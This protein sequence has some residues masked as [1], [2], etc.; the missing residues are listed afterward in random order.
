MRVRLL[1]C[2]LGALAV[3]FSV[4][5]I[6]RGCSCA[7]GGDPR[8]RLEH[9]AAA[10]IG[11]AL[12]QPSPSP[13]P[14]H[15][16]SAVR[17]GGGRNDIRYAVDEDFKSNLEDEI[18]VFGAASPC[19]FGAPVGETVAMYL[20]RHKG[21]WMSSSCDQT[22][23]DV[24]RRSAAPLP[25]PDGQGPPR[26]VLGGSMGAVRTFTLDA[27]GRT[28]R[29]AEGPGITSSLDLCPG[30]NVVAELAQGVVDDRFWKVNV[31]TRD[32]RTLALRS[33]YGFTSLET[34]NGVDS[35]G[36]GPVA[37]LDEEGRMLAVFGVHDN[38]AAKIVRVLGENETTIWEG[39]AGA[40]EFSDD[41]AEA[42]VASGNDLLVVD[43][44]TGATR[45]IARV[46]D[47]TARLDVSPDDTHAIYSSTGGERSDEKGHYV[48]DLTTG[49][50][51]RLPL[52]LYGYLWAGPREF[53]VVTKDSAVH[54]Y[55]LRLRETSTWPDWGGGGVVD[56]GVLYESAY[57]GLRA[58]SVRDGSPRVLRKFDFD[59]LFNL[60]VVPVPDRT[61]SGAPLPTTP[62]PQAQPSA[63]PASSGVART[64]A[65]FAGA[66]ALAAVAYVLK[67]RRP[68]DR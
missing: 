41:A 23:P 35:M 34:K 50:S 17:A 65:V 37:C 52:K 66:V 33:E 57:G 28:L 29:Y 64:V 14:V 39:T 2:F 67:R 5:P 63:A 6:A 61:G 25:A 19:G 45:K 60:V 24:L 36:A 32:V 56:G 58:A 1:G 68:A 42:F 49:R 9:A 15:T 21:R 27:R 48:V 62:A 3:L 53:I 55:D 10:F 18:T 22:T 4:T 11:R 44:K 30:A 16:A 46:P 13:T 26:F 7:G 47:G 31:A 40:F 51:E 43:L 38:R 12:P 8:E 54:V 20:F 59:Q